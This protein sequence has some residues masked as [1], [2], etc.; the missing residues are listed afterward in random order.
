MPILGSAYVMLFILTLII[1]A[2]NKSKNRKRGYVD[3]FKMT[4]ED[5]EKI[6]NS[7]E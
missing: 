5:I 1:E 2:S 6:M 3:H 4:K 7:D